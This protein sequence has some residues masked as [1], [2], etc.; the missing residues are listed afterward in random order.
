[1]CTR[2]YVF[3]TVHVGMGLRACVPAHMSVSC[4][5]MLKCNC[6]SPVPHISFGLPSV[7]LELM[8]SNVFYL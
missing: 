8:V 3:V 6:S 7:F 4:L 5:C 1:V 2:A